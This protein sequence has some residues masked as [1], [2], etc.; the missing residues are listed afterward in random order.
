MEVKSWKMQDRFGFVKDTN[1]K[2]TSGIVQLISPLFHQAQKRSIIGISG[3]IFMLGFKLVE[4]ETIITK[5][6]ALLPDSGL[7]GPEL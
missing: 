7:K 5:S 2:N 1:L 4:T 3:I 6:E